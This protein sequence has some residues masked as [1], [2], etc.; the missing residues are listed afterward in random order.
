MS[1]IQMSNH[2]TQAQT[3]DA[4]PRRA[5]SKHGI[6]PARR[7]WKGCLGKRGLAEAWGW[8]DLVGRSG[9]LREGVCTEGSR[10]RGSGR[11]QEKGRKSQDGAQRVRWMVE[12]VKPW[13][14]PCE[15][16]VDPRLCALSHGS[17]WRGFYWE[18]A[19]AGELITSELE[20]S[21]ATAWEGAVGMWVPGWQGSCWK[22]FRPHVMVQA[23]SGW[24]RSWGNRHTLSPIP[25]ATRYSSSLFLDSP[26][27]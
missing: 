7:C 11:F 4:P 27:I 2:K 13:M 23:L 14:R 18:G 1:Q 8:A 17:H 26:R 9:C 20:N 6:W 10:W 5:L 19:Q 21:L 25:R 15:Y 3:R 24:W 22:C 12:Q 16:M